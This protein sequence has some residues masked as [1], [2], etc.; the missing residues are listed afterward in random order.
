MFIIVYK[1]ISLPQIGNLK[2]IIRKSF[3]NE[4][5]KLCK[6]LEKQKEFFLCSFCGV[7]EYVCVCM[8]VLAYTEF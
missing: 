1:S 8:H 6:G 7:V 5:K 2:I 4:L 3:S